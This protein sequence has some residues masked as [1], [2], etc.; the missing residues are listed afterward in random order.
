MK[1][2]EL[3]YQ[4]PYDSPWLM[5][6]VGIVIWVSIWTAVDGLIVSGWFWRWLG[7]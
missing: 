7:V 3:R 6:P 4:Y 1:H 5:W 2:R